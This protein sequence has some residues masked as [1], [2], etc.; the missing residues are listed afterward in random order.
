MADSLTFERSAAPAP[1][2]AI[3]TFFINLLER[4]VAAQSV[5]IKGLPPMLFRFP[6]L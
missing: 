1:R 6:P 4:M 5:N 3:K 2:G